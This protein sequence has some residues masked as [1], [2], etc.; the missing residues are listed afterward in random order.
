MYLNQDLFDKKKKILDPDP[1]PS[2]IGY[3]IKETKKNKKNIN[4]QYRTVYKSTKS[5]YITNNHRII[6]LLI[7]S[8]SLQ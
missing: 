5:T 3:L 1:Q 7:K 2:T 4:Y 8:L 6:S